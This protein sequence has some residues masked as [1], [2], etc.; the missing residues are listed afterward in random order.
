MV[1]ESETTLILSLMETMTSSLPSIL[2]VDDDPDNFDV[3]ETLLS[4]HDYQLHY[5]SN[6]KMAIASLELLQPDLILL[7]VMMP[8]IDGIEVCRKIKAIPQWQ[9]V[10]I[11]MVTALDSKEDLSRCLATG[12]D[13]FISKPINRV[14]LIARV[15]SMLRIKSQY[16]ELQ[17]LLKSREDM[18]NMIVH[19]LRNPLM[20]VLF[21]LYLL[22]RLEL[23]DKI[24]DKIARCLLS[25][26][27]LQALINDLIVMGKME[28][29]HIKL[30]RVDVDLCT[31]VK[32]T[33]ENF[34]AI[35]AQKNIK[36]ICQVPDPGGKIQVDDAL[37]TRVLDNLL[38]NATKFSPRHSQV[39]INA[40]YLEL[41]GAK[42]QVIDTGPGVPKEFRDNIF[43]KYEI[44]RI[45][46]NVSQIGLG[47]AFCKMVIEAHGGQIKV[48]P[49]Q[50]QGSIF[51]ITL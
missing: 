39:I 10:P 35:A 6:G 37:F 13:D 12:A 16:N 48:I 19:D 21:S 9:V 34:Q 11:I 43:K 15:N 7:D 40:T 5:A 29:S 25:A 50:P 41:Q 8:D 47:L 22:G 26:Q 27:R 14:E 20:S 36:L 23:P 33:V 17:A 49:N 30:N 2:I 4:D 32:S 38:S 24:E 31:S 45:M 1:S 3:I 18:V 42:I 46:P 51:E 28:H 44:G